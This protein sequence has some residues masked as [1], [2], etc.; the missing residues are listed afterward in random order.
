MIT[1]ETKEMVVDLLEVAHGFAILGSIMPVRQAANAC[2]LHRDSEAVR[3]AHACID[4][5]IPTASIEETPA[6]KPAL[7]VYAEAIERA[8][9]RAKQGR[10]P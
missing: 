1:D 2:D 3:L 8:I 4:A 7:S 6:R 5:E 10:W 9:D